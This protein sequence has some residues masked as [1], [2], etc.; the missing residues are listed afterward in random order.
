MDI[1]LVAVQIHDGAIVDCVWNGNV[2]NL[3][4]EQLKDVKIRLLYLAEEIDNIMKEK[5]YA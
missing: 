3:N 2:D 5:R 1:N 4:A